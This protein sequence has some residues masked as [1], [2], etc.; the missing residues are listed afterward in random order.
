LAWDRA[1]M[2]F[3]AYTHRAAFLSALAD[4]GSCYCQAVTTRV[5]PCRVGVATHPDASHTLC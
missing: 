3:C 1:V 5:Y 2:M 4:M